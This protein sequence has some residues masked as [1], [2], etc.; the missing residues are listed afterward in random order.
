MAILISNN[1][2]SKLDAAIDDSQ[3]S[4]TVTTGDGVKFPDTSSGGYFYATIS[5]GLFV[6]IVKVT[7]R[8]TD[9][10]TVVRGQDGTS[11]HAFT[12]AAKFEQRWNKQ[13]IEDL[14]ADSVTPKVV[15]IGLGVAQ[16]DVTFS[17]AKL[18]ANYAVVPCFECD[19]DN[20]N[21]FSYYLKNKTVNGFSIVMNAP[22]DSANY[23]LNYTI[24]NTI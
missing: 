7:A 5:E 6:E 11:G 9:S 4:L 24:G 13:Q 12:S 22:T 16:I 17:T 10:F 20:P 3:T 23:K 2:G 8:A 14:L 18:N 1:A 15:S 19:D 21:F